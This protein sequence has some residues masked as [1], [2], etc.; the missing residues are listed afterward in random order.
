VCV[1]VAFGIQHAMRTRHTVIC[2]LPGSTIFFRII[3]KSDT[4]FGKKKVME[5]KMCFD[6]LQLLSETFFILRRTERDMNN[7]VY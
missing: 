5:H 4:I 6:F 7:N 1:F 3:S 2:G